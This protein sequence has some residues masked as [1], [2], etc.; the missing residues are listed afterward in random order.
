MLYI[1]KAQNQMREVGAGLVEFALVAGA[2]VIVVIIL[3]TLVGS[4]YG[5]IGV[6]VAGTNP[7]NW[8]K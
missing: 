1:I 7:V 4:M 5:A 2:M 3:A 8:F 6:E